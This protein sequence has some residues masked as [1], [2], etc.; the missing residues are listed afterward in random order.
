MVVFI[1]IFGLVTGFS[2]GLFAIQKSTSTTAHRYGQWG[3]AAA[4]A[5]LA[6]IATAVGTRINLDI[7]LVQRMTDRDFIVKE[8]LATFAFYCVL[9]AEAV[10]LARWLSSRTSGFASFLVAHIPA[11][12]LAWLLTS[13]VGMV[14]LP[15]S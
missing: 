14:V 6:A 15:D 9:A 4:I 1:I 13:F 3:L 11:T 7:D 2:S 5:L 8:L 10:L 12:I